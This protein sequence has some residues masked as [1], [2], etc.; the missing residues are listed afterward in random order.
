MKI[1]AAKK[2]ED[3]TRE[4]LIKEVR[5]T[6][7]WI[8]AIDDYCWKQADEIDKWRGICRASIIVNII[9]IILFLI[10]LIK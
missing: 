7:Q 8:K 4:E 10:W 3:M 1:E 5:I 2:I 6:Q 9:F